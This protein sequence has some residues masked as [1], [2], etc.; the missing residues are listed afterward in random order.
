MAGG[1][2][3]SSTKE[4]GTVSTEPPAAGENADK[5]D[6]SKVLLPVWFILMYSS[7]F[8]DP[9]SAPPGSGQNVSKLIEK[10]LKSFRKK[11][12]EASEQLLAQVKSVM[13][14]VPAPGSTPPGSFKNGTVLSLNVRPHIN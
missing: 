13:A 5:E 11:M 10:E 8:Q 3:S 2:K 9:G 6:V 1:G 14:A 4:V 12:M 7:Y